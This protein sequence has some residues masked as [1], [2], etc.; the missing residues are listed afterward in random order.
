MK[1]NKKVKKMK[2][3]R[4]KNKKKKVIQTMIIK[5]SK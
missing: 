3:K 4:N 5:K 2:R 1:L